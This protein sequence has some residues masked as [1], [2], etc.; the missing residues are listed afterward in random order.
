MPPPDPTRPEVPHH[1]P[2]RQRALVSLL[3][4]ENPRVNA[5]SRRA[6]I[7]QGVHALPALERAIAGEDARLRG[8]ARLLRDELRGRL[9]EIEIRELGE[10]LD[11]DESALEAG[12]VLLA[13]TR[14]FD[15]DGASVRA[16]L[17]AMADDLGSRLGAER[18]AAAV[19]AGMTRFLSTELG[20]Q[21]HLRNYYDPENCYLDRVLA[22]RLGIPISLSAIWLFVARRLEI[23]LIGIGLPGHFIVKHVG[24][25]PGLYIDPFYGGRVFSERECVRYLEARSIE[26]EPSLLLPMTDGAMLLRMMRNLVQMHRARGDV[27]RIQLLQRMKSMLVGEEVSGP[28]LGAGEAER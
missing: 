12:C 7:Q 19:V 5:E 26:F 16:A 20:F 17:D 10:R 9:L 15:L 2:D 28:E 23:P 6:L 3:S 1:D 11:H 4:D 22:R 18:D 21:G 14:D 27:A 8:R 25:E 13:R 24:A